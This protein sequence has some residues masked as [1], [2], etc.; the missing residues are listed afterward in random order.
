MNPFLKEFFYIYQNEKNT[1]YLLP[2]RSKIISELKQ[3][4]LSQTEYLS[5]LTHDKQYKVLY[6]Q[7]L[8]NINYFLVDFIKI[9]LEKIQKNFYIDESF[10]SVNEAKFHKKLINRFKDLDIYVKSE[11]KYNDREYVGFIAQEDIGN[12]IIEGNSVDISIGDFFV[13][14]FSEIEDLLKEGKVLLV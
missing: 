3:E 13:V 6:E 5:E 11:S 14:K 12:V 8:E 2:C 7:E 4:I 10:M 9:R 1:I